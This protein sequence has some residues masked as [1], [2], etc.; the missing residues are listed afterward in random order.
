MDQMD[1]RNAGF[2]VRSDHR[3]VAAKATSMIVL[4]LEAACTADTKAPSVTSS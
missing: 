1:G 2:D 3:A 4:P